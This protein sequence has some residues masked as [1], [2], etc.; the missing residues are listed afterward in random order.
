MNPWI[1]DRYKNT[2]AKNSQE[3]KLILYLFISSIKLIKKI[4]FQNDFIQKNKKSV[5]KNFRLLVEK[6]RSLFKQE[7]DITSK[8]T[9]SALRNEVDRLLEQLKKSVIINNEH[10]KIRKIA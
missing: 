8:T 10:L 6:S 4:F 5:P 9:S 1:Q 7:I 2:T 3:F